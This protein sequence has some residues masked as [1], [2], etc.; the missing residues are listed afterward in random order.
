V[1]LIL[2]YFWIIK[3]LTTAMG[4]ATSDYMVRA[5]NPVTAVLLGFTGFVIAMVLQ[6]RRSAMWPGSTGWPSPWS[7]CSARRP[8]TCCTSSSTSH[9]PGPGR[10]PY[11][12][13]PFDEE[14]YRPRPRD[15]E[16]G[17]PPEGFFAW[18]DR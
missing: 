16:P 18:D 6:L 10:S 1:P 7:R 17:R 8:P 4:E 5:I 11:Q 15:G 12:R 3:L 9:Q 14:P 13:G 2:V